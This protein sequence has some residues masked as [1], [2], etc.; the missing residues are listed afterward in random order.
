M[1]HRE[2]WV[3]TGCG[4]EPGGTRNPECSPCIVATEL[5]AKRPRLPYPICLA[6]GNANGDSLQRVVRQLVEGAM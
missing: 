6:V 4:R 2:C 5:A 1:E 3:V